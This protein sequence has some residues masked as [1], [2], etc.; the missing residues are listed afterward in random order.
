MELTQDEQDALSYA[1]VLIENGVPIFLAQ[2]HVK[3]NVWNANG[4]HGGTGYWFPPEWEKS[5]PDLTV[6]DRWEPGVALCAVMGHGI[7]L[8][9]VDPRSGGDD[10]YAAMLKEGVI[11]E[12]FGRQAT[13]SGGFHL[14][15]AS[16][17]VRSLDKVRPG[18][19]VKA[20][21]DGVGH[22]FAFLAPTRKTSKITEMVGSY[23][24]TEPPNLDR[25][26]LGLDRGIKLAEEINDRHNSSVGYVVVGYDGASYEDLPAHHKQAA[27]EYIV[28]LANS[29][30]DKL[31]DAANWPEGKT[32][33]WGRGWEALSRDVAWSFAKVAAAPW[34]GLSADQ[35]GDLIE[36]IT[37]EEMW[38]DPQC[39]GKWYP[40]LVAKAAEGLMA[41]PP[42]PVFPPLD[43]G[44]WGLTTTLSHIRQA[45]YSRYLS[46][47]S[48]LAYVLARVLVEV[49]V[50][51]CYL[52][53][54]VGARATLNL[55]FALVGS[56]G[57]GKSTLMETS[58]E[59]IGLVGQDQLELEKSIGS[60]E[61]IVKSFLAPATGSQKLQLILDPR[62]LFM[63]DE[64]GQYLA[65]SDRVGSTLS[66]VLRSA[67]TGS[68][69]GQANADA[70]RDR[71]VPSGSYRFI[72][73]AG[74]QPSHAD[75]LLREADL[76][77]PQRMLWVN[78]YDPD[79]PDENPAWPGSLD[80]EI[81]TNLPVEMEYPDHIKA[82][83]RAARLTQVRGQGNPLES[84]A[85]LTQ[86]K[87]AAALA[88]LHRETEITD[89]WWAMA[90]TLCRES[91]VLQEW[92]SKD[93][94]E[95]V[96]RS[97]IVEATRKVRVQAEVALDSI[98][99]VEKNVVAKLERSEQE[100][101]NVTSLRPRAELREYY[102]E[103]LENLVND[104]RIEV[105]E[106]PNKGGIA[107][108][109]RL[110]KSA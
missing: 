17:G 36:S 51:S 69:M 64:V 23:Q 58:R 55:G 87:V 84:H 90:G 109:V 82:E 18:V 2:P 57:G 63:T 42:W 94:Q 92:L 101:H 71:H 6:L 29:W 7:D 32:D 50:G 103:A 74:I 30:R 38:T 48:L 76:G 79:Y 46:P 16:M 66:S 72:F 85:M 52:P 3:G 21:I 53:P 98:K 35:A 99:R 95:R 33:D 77:T 47:P 19:D 78:S 105:E 68:I 44:F 8:I 12:V 65:S 24:W 91:I 14:F 86:L 110:V 96:Y 4:G 67:L 59:L 62:R 20:G 31:T 54:T 83:V 60:G 106:Y 37:P 27:D 88:L 5:P 49:P 15:V 61:G 89:R 104:K 22:G 70:S 81:P 73:V 1:R 97:A 11:P 26:I 102:E 75:R 9:D 25:L 107:R 56:S 28:E 108:R 45:A 80:W 43:E 40:G 100:W 41:E 93:S 13:V 39:S 34:S 10:S